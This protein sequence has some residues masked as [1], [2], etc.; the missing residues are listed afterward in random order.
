MA[1]RKKSASRKRTTRRR[2]SAVGFVDTGMIT[3]FLMGAAGYVAGNMV[4]K[5]IPIN[6]NLAKGGVKLVG[7]MFIPKLVKG[8]AGT[9]VAIGLGANGAIDIVRQFAPGI[10]SG[11]DE[12]VILL[13]GVDQLG[14]L[15]TL[16]GEAIEIDTLGEVDQLGE[17]EFSDDDADPMSGIP[18]LN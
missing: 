4:G 7:A 6:N 5:M 17:A 1:K 3:N 11:V 15:P 2:R 12:P 10:V 13:S 18:T 8:P 16:I 9:A 14:E